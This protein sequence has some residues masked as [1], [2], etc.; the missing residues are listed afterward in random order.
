MDRYTHA[1]AWI[2]T[3]HTPQLY[4]SLTLAHSTTCGQRNSNR[5]TQTISAEQGR[6]LGL[7]VGG[8]SAQKAAVGMESPGESREAEQLAEKGYRWHRSCGQR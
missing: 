1:R 6:R 4:D 5:C 2:D 8:L 7:E 3:H